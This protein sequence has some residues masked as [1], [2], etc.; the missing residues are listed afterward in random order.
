MD[1]RLKTGCF[2]Q[3]VSDGG[4]EIDWAG[5][6]TIKNSILESNESFSSN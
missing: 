6:E 4:D 1:H 2:K 3:E 5:D